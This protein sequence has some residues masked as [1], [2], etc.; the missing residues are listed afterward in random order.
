MTKRST[1]KRTA[2]SAPGTKLLITTSAL[3]ATLGGWVGLAYQAAADTIDTPP[4]PAAVVE[5]PAVALPAPPIN[6]SFAP[7]P[8]LAALPP[9]PPDLAIAPPPAAASNRSA[10]VDVA[11]VAAPAAAPVVA[12]PAAAPAVPAAP[13]LRAVSAP[14]APAPVA[15]TRSSK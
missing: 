10:T 6:L 3:A 15:R 9:A 2:N 11:P 7:I 4:A 14:A 12:A 8:T 13:A 5:Q 1:P